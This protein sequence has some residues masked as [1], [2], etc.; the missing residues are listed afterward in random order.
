MCDNDEDTLIRV[1]VFEHVRRLCE[2]HHHLTA[3]ELSPGFVFDGE[4]V[5]LINPQSG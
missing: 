3:T 4:P 1:A 5:P 2:V